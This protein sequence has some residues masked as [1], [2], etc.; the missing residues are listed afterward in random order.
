MWRCSQEI[1]VWRREQRS[2]RAAE[3]WG[4]AEGR[5]WKK[6]GGMG[7]PGM[8]SLGGMLPITGLG[9]A[10]ALWN[11]Q[12]R[13]LV[14]AFECYRFNWCVRCNGHKITIGGSVCICNEGKKNP[15][16]L[17]PSIQS[18]IAISER[19]PLNSS[20]ICVS[21]RRG[22]GGGGEGEGGGTSS[23]W[24]EWEEVLSRKCSKT[25]EGSSLRG[26][27]VRFHQVKGAKKSDLCVITSHVLT[28]KIQ[29]TKKNPII[30]FYLIKICIHFV[31]S[32]LSSC[33][34]VMLTLRLC[35]LCK[36]QR[37]TRGR[38]VGNCNV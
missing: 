34:K 37:H 33:Q 21:E 18:L 31:T 1:D 9:A 11:T 25:S 12:K 28:K 4:G 26:A 30:M 3:R 35:S 13:W 16:P 14:H 5:T 24:N 8:A 6:P 32:A 10:A 19:C 2:G 23:L 7:P 22:Q 15:A 38:P 20:L 17:L 36:N 27:Y 29:T